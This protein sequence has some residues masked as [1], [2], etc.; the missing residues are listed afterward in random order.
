[1][2]RQFVL[3]QKVPIL[4]KFD[5]QGFNFDSIPVKFR[6]IPVCPKKFFVKWPFSKIVNLF[7]FIFKMKWKGE[8]VCWKA[9]A[10]NFSGKQE[11]YWSWT[12]NWIPVNRI[13]AKFDTATIWKVKRYGNVFTQIWKLQEFSLPEFT[14]ITGIHRNYRNSPEFTGINEFGHNSHESSHISEGS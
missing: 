6:W 9:I 4:P 14:G 8:H 7:Y 10:V 2:H 12:E 5:S 11:F 3:R 13:S 1:M